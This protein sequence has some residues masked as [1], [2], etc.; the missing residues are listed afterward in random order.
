QGSSL[1]LASYAGNSL[2]MLNPNR[3]SPYNQQW[4]FS[5][6][7]QL[8][9]NIV[10]E[11][12][13]VGML[14][15]KELESYNLNDLPDVYLAL[16]S[17]QNASVHNP[18]FGLFPSNSTL[19][20]SSTTTQRQLWL[21]YP[22]YTSLTID[23]LNTGVTTYNAL[24]ARIQKRLTHG[25]SVIGSY[26]FSK[27]MHNNVTS[28]VNTRHYRSIGQ[29]DQPELIRLAVTYDLPVH[30]AGSGYR[31]ILREAAGDWALTG[32]WS[33]DSGLPLTITQANG[34]PIVVGNPQE[35]G[36]VDQRL[37]DRVVNGVVQ[38]PYF[39]INAFQPL[40]SQYLVS[41][42]VPYI[43]QLRAPVFAYLNTSLF[44]NF[45]IRERLHA[46]LRLEAYNATNHPYFNS[47]GTNM[48]SPAT[49]GV[50]TGAS[51]SRSMQAGLKI[52][53]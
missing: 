24:Q 44:K 28:V 48:S 32:E 53:F 40:S 30:F 6:Q 43:S 23:G 5:V 12:A 19:G 36:P 33:L 16:G 27:Q 52:V 39:N 18:F 9:A 42:Q 11:A 1:G 34:R 47:P 37:G 51:N 49:F 20:A 29:Y 31:R 25:L 26:T 17:A 4:Q 7:Q 41:P 13:Y 35:S 10:I 15:V 3:V 46:E 45:A 38:N 8:P 50:I 14:S 21:Q 2:T 22:Q